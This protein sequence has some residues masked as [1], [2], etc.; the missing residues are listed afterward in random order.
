MNPVSMGPG[1]GSQL[2]GMPSYRV[3]REA[4]GPLVRH[5]AGTV[6]VALIQRRLQLRP[7]ALVL[8]RDRLERDE[9][10]DGDR[11]SDRHR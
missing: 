5:L 11:G 4:E 9:T 1:F 3:L 7:H 10:L 8:V 6:E 2:G